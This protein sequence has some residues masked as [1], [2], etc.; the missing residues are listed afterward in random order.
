MNP[1]VET[2][3]MPLEDHVRI[4]QVRIA[5]YWGKDIEEVSDEDEW[6]LIDIQE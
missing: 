6:R 3:A 2:K 5:R 1:G 4:L